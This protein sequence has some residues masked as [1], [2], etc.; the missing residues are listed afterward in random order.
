M[1]ISKEFIG[2]SID[3]CIQ[4]AKQ[5]LTPGRFEHSFGVMQVMRELAPLYGL[6]QS[7]A[8]IAGILHDIAKE[9]AP[10]DLIKLANENGISLRT[11]YDEH[12]LFLH[13]PISALYVAQK[14]AITDPYLLDA[15]SRH[16]YLGDGVALSTSFCWCLRF[17]DM[18][19]PS[20]DWQDLKSQLRPLAYS[21]KL[22]EGAYTLVNWIIPFH[23]SLSLPIHPNIE[24]LFHEL[25]ILKN[26][27]NL[28]KVNNLP[29]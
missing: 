18:L 15:I 21:G 1:A 6:N 29:A 11:E 3:D 23:E 14:L 9:F 4:F 22:G 12:P 28:D 2:V 16:S 25:S 5:K 10:D 24:R 7:K 19:E 8:M 27:K 17:A 20:R 26:E 13:G